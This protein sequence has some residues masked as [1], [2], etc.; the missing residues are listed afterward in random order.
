MVAG[1]TNSGRIGLDARVKSLVQ[2]LRADATARAAFVCAA[3]GSLVVYYMVGRHQWFVRDDWDYVLGRD[4]TLLHSG[5]RHWILD[6]QAGH[7]LTVPVVLF[8]YT[9]SCFGLGSYWPFLIPTMAAHLA[10]VF[11]V[12]ALCVRAGVSAWT[13][14]LACSM[15]LVFG[16]GWENMIFAIQISFNLSLVAF[17]A[18]LVLA[19]HEGDVDRR[20]YL[21]SALAL[22]GVV[23]SG[24][25]PIF[26]VGVFTYLASRRRWKAAL[27]IVAPQSALYLWWSVFWEADTSSPR[28]DKW[29]IPRFV[30]RGLTTT[31]DGLVSVPGLSGVAAL[32]CIAVVASRRFDNRT[33]SIF[34]ALGATVSTMFIAI[35]FERVGFGSAIATS[36][37]YAHIGAMVTAPILAMAVDQSFRISRH[38]RHAGLLILGASGLLNLSTLYRISLDW[39]RQTRV[40]RDTFNLVAG[41]DLVDQVPGDRIFFP[42]SPAVRLSTLPTLV[43]LGALHPRTPVTTEETGRVRLALGLSPD[44]GP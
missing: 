25:G 35:G 12:R 42:E 15:L 8:H 30:V 4:D 3:I 19:D 24:F 26:M 41:S 16:A 6:P 23:S 44:L 18:Q 37:R 5:W 40:Q 33:H 27:V 36:S 14:T 34:L 38:T 22:I 32:G 9:T 2:R 29:Q 31:F 17:L 1:A 13:T 43:R 11:L 20:D 21:A 28:G 10:A 39:S 7:W